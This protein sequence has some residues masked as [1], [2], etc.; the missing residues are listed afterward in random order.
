VKAI[1]IAQ[2]TGDDPSVEMATKLFRF[3]DE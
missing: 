1:S 2:K 3:F